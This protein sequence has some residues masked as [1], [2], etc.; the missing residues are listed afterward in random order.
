MRISRVVRSTRLLAM[1]LLT[2]APAAHAS[3]PVRA[4]SP[5]ESAAGNAIRLSHGRFKD[6][7]VY[8]PVGPPTGFVLL[9]SGEQGWNSTA[10]AMARQLVQQGAMVAG[11]DWA[12]FK[13]NLE[14]DGDQCVFPDGD[15]ENLSHFV[16]AYFH[17][18]TYL[19]PIL[20]GVSSGAAMA[21]AVLAQAPRNTFAAALTLGFCP[22]LNL[23]KPLCKGS[24]LE[25]TRGARGHGMEFLPVK[26][27][28]NPW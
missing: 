28:A 6:F 13:A 25:S 15:L 18:T 4:P 5:P 16:Q 20:V 10:D 9:L 19:S 14:A 11:V 8:K 23:E 7:L 12:K 3:E 27:L 26:N 2:A 24:G 21:Y 17:T 1:S 22:S